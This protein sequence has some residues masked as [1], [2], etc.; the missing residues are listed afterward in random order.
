MFNFDYNS[1]RDFVKE[2]CNRRNPEVDTNFDHFLYE[3]IRN[4]VLR[5]GIR[6]FNAVVFIRLTPYSETNQNPLFFFNIVDNSRHIL[7]RVNSVSVLTKDKRRIVDLIYRVG[8]PLPW[9]WDEAVGDIVMLDVPKG[10]PRYWQILRTSLPNIFYQDNAILLYPNPDDVYSYYIDINYFVRETVISEAYNVLKVIN[11]YPF[12]IA[13]FVNAEVLRYLGEIE[14]AKLE[15]AQG[16]Q[17]TLEKAAIE[18]RAEVPPV[19]NIS[20]NIRK[21]YLF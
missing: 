10:E 7:L 1:F 3:G 6:D 18:K 13:R 11:K 8:L 2:Y 17:E 16:I 5:S 9:A 12:Q 21:K 4:F 19:F 20:F 14:L 15:E